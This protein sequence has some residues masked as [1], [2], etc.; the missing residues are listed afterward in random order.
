MYNTIDKLFKNHDISDKELTDLITSAEYDDYLFEKADIVRKKHYG[1]SVYVRGL[2][3]ISNYCKNNCYYC[4]IRAENSLVERYRLLPDEILK[5]CETGYS[6][7]SRTFVLQGGEDIYYN[8]DV[9]CSIISDIKASFS[10]CAVTLS[11]GE[12]SYLSYSRFFEAGADRYLLRHET[13]DNDHYRLL[14]PQSMDPDN[15]KKCLFD[16]K[17]IGFQTGAGFM[18]GSP[19]QKTGNIISDIRFLKTLNPEMIG[20]GPFISHKNT[21]FGNYE[22]GSVQLTLRIIAL[23]RLMFPDALIPATTALGTMLDDGR[24]RGIKAGANVV[25]PNL[26]PQDCRKKYEIYQNKLYSGEESAQALLKLRKKIS[27][28]GYTVSM[29]RGDHKPEN[30]LT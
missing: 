19:F 18:V 12:K 28:I 3:E 29:E 4:G 27:S 10:G 14:H 20:I 23:V 24:E 17:K 30:S 11:L 6:L 26:S 22:N 1:N 21:P 7:G 2:I 25:M 16:L 15:R 8:D 9:V 13:A 5:C